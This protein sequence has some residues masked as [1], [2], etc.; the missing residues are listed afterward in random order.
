MKPLCFVAMPF[1]LKPD[2][3]GRMIDFE[4]VY[5]EI[6]R[7]GVEAA[8]MEPLRGDHEQ[9]GGMIHKAMFERLVLCDFAVADLTTANANVFYELGIRHGIRPAST[10]LLFASEGRLPFDVGAIRAIPYQLDPGGVP[11]DA[12]ANAAMIASRL[13]EC[14]RGA[15]DSPVFQLLDGMSPPEIARLRSDAFRD[16]VEYSRQM[17]RELER[18]RRTGKAA[19]AAFEEQ[20]GAI[21]GVEAG[22][23]VDLF[24]SHRAV[25]AF[26]K[27]I[28]LA[29]RMPRVLAGTTLVQEQHAFALNRVGRG[30]EAEMILRDLIAERGPSSETYGLLGRVYKDRAE[31]AATAGN[32]VQARGHL[33]RA[34]EA[35]RKGFEC[36]WRDAFPGINAVTLME[37]RDPPDPERHRILPVVVYSAERRLASSKADYF[38]HATVLEAAVLVDDRARAAR[39]AADALALVTEGFQPQTTARNLGLIREAREKRG[40]DVAWI[41][42]IE[43]DLTAARPSD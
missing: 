13:R 8:D 7:P 28:D 32:A 25:G 42:A 34:I 20:L 40:E 33:D 3:T 24:L 39:A 16:R 9:S 35:Y 11:M 10:V 1:G 26:Q 29:E 18:A 38:D 4:R 15:T 27:M 37:I 43:N 14:R 5:A 30:E 17:K 36:D 22:V 41:A 23:V 12:A 21:D 31:R 19:V 6:I 2:A